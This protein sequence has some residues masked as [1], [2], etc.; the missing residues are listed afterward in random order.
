MNNCKNL[1]IE[2]VTPWHGDV[3][4]HSSYKYTCK[5]TNREVI[6]YIH[7]NDKRCKNYEFLED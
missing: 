5:L 3:F 4:D 2:D 7:C 6:T 1:I